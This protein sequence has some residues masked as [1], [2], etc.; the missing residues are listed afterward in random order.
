ME[1]SDWACAVNTNSQLHKL[2]ALVNAAKLFFGKPFIILKD[3]RAVI[4]FRAAPSPFG[5]RLG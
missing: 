3:G 2:N 5:R 1:S 4:L